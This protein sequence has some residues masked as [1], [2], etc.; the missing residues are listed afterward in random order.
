[1]IAAPG[2]I[3]PEYSSKAM[4]R[5]MLLVLM[6]GLGAC[7]GADSG[8]TAAADAQGWQLASGRAPSR[9]TFAA[10]AA[11]CQD[12]VGRSTGGSFDSCLADL[13]LHHNR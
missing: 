11:A 10:I 1:M 4:W 2:G 12:R 3:E 5:T 6:L 13:G 7:G 9:D 8:D